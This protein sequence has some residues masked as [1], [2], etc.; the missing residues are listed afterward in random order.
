MRPARSEA[1]LFSCPR[2]DDCLQEGS[3]RGPRRSREP[4]WPPRGRRRPAQCPRRDRQSQARPCPSN[5]PSPAGN[6]WRHSSGADRPNSRFWFHHCSRRR[7]IAR[8]HQ[9]PAEPPALSK[10]GRDQAVARDRLQSSRRIR[11]AAPA[12]Y[13]TG[14]ATSRMSSQNA[15]SRRHRHKGGRK[16]SSPARRPPRGGAL[17]RRANRAGTAAMPCAPRPWAEAR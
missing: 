8:G 13:A 3:Q 6:G 4:P 14:A 17:L 5:R 11:R 15:A 10:S 12:R 2:Q 9:P 16:S 1:W 7:E